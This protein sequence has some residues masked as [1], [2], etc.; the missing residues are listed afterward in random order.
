MNYYAN[1]RIL[2]NIMSNMSVM[3]KKERYDISRANQSSTKTDVEM[4]E[5]FC[6][7]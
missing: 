7:T 2:R 3:I 5:L 4:G 6:K 1:L